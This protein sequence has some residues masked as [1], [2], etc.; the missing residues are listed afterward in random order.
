MPIRPRVPDP[1]TTPAT[2]CER[3][4]LKVIQVFI[5]AAPANSL[6]YICD[7]EPVAFTENMGADIVIDAN[8]KIKKGR[9]LG[10]AAKS[11]KDE[12]FYNLHTKTCDEAVKKANKKKP[13]YEQEGDNAKDADLWAK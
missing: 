11:S 7:A 12:P 5:E 2:C 1:R 4:G 10:N 8:G 3:C 9:L 6:S 13:K